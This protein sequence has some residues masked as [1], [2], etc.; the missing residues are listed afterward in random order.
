MLTSIFLLLFQGISGGI[1]G[2]ITNKYAVNMLF[3]EYT[4]L[5]LGGVIKKKKEQF[6][7]E[8]SELV[9]RDIINAQTLN[10]A[11]SNKN[12]NVYIEQIAGT[13][14]EKGIN[15]SFA[16]TKLCEITDFSNSIVKNQE[17]I[18]ENLNKVLPKLLDNI[19]MNINL[20]DILTQNQ[21]S[22]IVECSY[23]IFVEE[24]EKDNILNDIIPGLYK[25]SSNITL[26]NIFSDEVQ[27]KFTRNLT[28]RVMDIIEEDILA[29]EEGCKIYFDKILSAINID[30]TLVKLQGLIGDYEINRFITTSEEEDFTVELFKKINEFINTEKGKEV[31]NNIIDE[32]FLI[33][34]DIDFTIYE[35][36]PP[37]MEKSLTEF[38]E[39]I[40][41]K[42]MPYISEWI[43]SN[44]SSFD[45]MIESA[46]DE[47]IEGIDGNIK[48]III[49]KVR[50]ALMG[51]ISSQNDI[52]TKIID[53]LNDSFDNESYSKLA[54]SIINYLKNEKIKDIVELIEKQNIF[55]STK[56]MEF[57]IKQF[58]TQGKKLLGIIIKSQFSKK[59]H[60]V[61]K[62]DLV[63]LFNTK[64][65]PILYNNIFKNKDKLSQKINSLVEEF[66]ISKGTEIFNK[67]LS[68]L[69]TDN[70]VSNFSNTVVKSVGKLFSENSSTYKA[71]IQQFICSKV[72]NINLLST[73]NSYKVDISEFIV[74]NAIEVHKEIVDKYMDYEVKDLV[75][76]YFDKKQLTDLLVN[77]GYPMLINN[78][79]NLL[80]GNIKKTVSNNLE[81]YDE[82]EICNI[83]QDFM[84]DQLKPLSVFGGVLGVIVGL[85]Y[86][87]AYPGSVGAYGFPSSISSM[88]IS[89]VIMAGIGYIT[90]VIALWMIFHPYKENKIMAK[91]PFLK[92]FALGYIPAHKNEFAVSMAKLIDEELLN[93]QEINKVFNLQR[94]NMKSLLT[95][96]V[97]NNTYQVLVKLVRDK[98]RN[99]A[100]YIYEKILKYCNDDS[101]LSK[102]ISKVIANTKLNKFIKKEHIL[103][104]APE[105]LGKLKNIKS[106][107]VKIAESK[108]DS[109]HKFNDIL[110]E[111]V[112]MNIND[113][114]KNQMNMLIE[115]HVHKIKDV[116][117]VSKVINDYSKDY[118]IQIRKSCK[119]V[120]EEKSLNN[121]KNNMEI[122]AEKYIFEDLKIHISKNIEQFLCS[123]LDEDN[124]IGSIF[125]G[126][127][128]EIIDDN[129]YY[130]TNI[131]TNKFI[132]YLQAN[133][134]DLT[135]NVQQTIKD[136]LNF[137]EKI[138]YS[139][140]GG[141]DIADRVV[142]II[143]DKKL[144][145][146]IE[147]ESYKI[148]DMAKL[149]LNDSI[150]PIK[151]STLKLKADE[152]NTSMLFDNIFEKLN[153]SVN[154]R[155]HIR[156]SINLISD[157]L[158]STP[159]IEYLKLCNLHNLD[160][161]YK[162]VYNEVTIIKE[163]IHNSIINNI[164]QLSIL[165]GEFL[166]EKLIIPVLNSNNSKIFQ[167]I[168]SNDIEYSVEN[169]LKLIS[170][171]QE[172]KKY[173]TIFLERFY[174]N[175]ISKL[176]IEQIASSDILSN[177]IEK[178][179]N[180][181]FENKLFNENN[182]KLLEEI[183]QNASDNNLDFMTDDTKYYL[184]DKTILTGLL[185]ISDYIVPI[186]Q[187]IDLKNITNK[188][189]D[190]LNP[191][192][193]DILFNSFAGEFFNKLRIYGVFGFV[194]GINS[195]LSIVLWVMDWNYSNSSPKKDLI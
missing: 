22:K 9:E 10:N 66:M 35:I 156:N 135:L 84:G 63:K 149:A 73:L 30:L 152:I 183:I 65:K 37:E 5:K 32:I 103:N 19:F 134:Y 42:V 193:I 13:F 110:P 91:V 20:D 4:P 122:K 112:Y 165:T 182:I 34:K 72:K 43:S 96:L 145:I 27:K 114:M 82:D 136:Q 109:N 189:I 158:M 21:I 76:T 86:A 160:L 11:I 195:A 14:F 17:F 139:T 28:K 151:T 133:R 23:E 89:C 31:I 163:D 12:L 181:I 105:L 143:L 161:V 75:S 83:V 39:T 50:N 175:I 170:S 46:I 167:G 15:N 70:E 48:K 98:K 24:F 57:I 85:L 148:V 166:N 79:P 99:L 185:S 56:L 177:D 77:K 58:D 116:D 192:E 131:I 157:S 67:N 92:K 187:E 51:D 25:E 176:Q 62:F 186:L 81:K 45:E 33:G 74:D 61:V 7:E 150:Y 174:D 87:I 29:D 184:T 124:S 118:D 108:L 191:R 120:F 80:D 126:K 164:D 155:M 137:F 18:R 38:I 115:E 100:T 188:Q 142:S 130:L 1:A 138:A 129:I 144:P 101:Y 125:N 128:K 90:N 8:I 78:L 2:Y 169:I 106:S 93:K 16:N 95:S 132:N 47:S 171:S 6:I 60:K 154:A 41:P 36:L 141:D 49:S 102:R 172:S 68:E 3:K 146:M 159:I 52:V 194:F 173:L 107:L 40:V 180:W 54:D 123:E 153:D 147:D 119:E 104:I 64:L 71:K 55:N 190:L 88:V 59:I 113:Y 140:F 53:Y 178:V 97:T 44:K 111:T 69:L 94:N 121:I 127:V 26:S 162:K 179:N 117:F 168:E